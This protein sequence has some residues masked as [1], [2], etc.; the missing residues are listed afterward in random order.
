MWRTSASPVSRRVLRYEMRAK[1]SRHPLHELLA[2]FGSRRRL[3]IMPSYRVMCRMLLEL[4]PE[5]IMEEFRCD[6]PELQEFEY[7]F[8][9]PTLLIEDEC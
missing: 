6:V 9:K 4:L 7:E 5:D 2:T 1:V 8:C 3:L